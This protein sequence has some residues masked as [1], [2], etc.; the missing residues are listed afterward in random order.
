MPA[1]VRA[2]ESRR[3]NPGTPQD[4]EPEAW[5]VEGIDD[6]AV[7]RG[8]LESHVVPYREI[9]AWLAQKKPPA[10]KGGGVGPAGGV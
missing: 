4:S 3:R 1:R 2:L 5:H 9:R 6:D 7:T 8:F 10:G